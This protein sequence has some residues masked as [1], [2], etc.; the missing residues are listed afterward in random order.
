MESGEM[1]RTLPF[2]FSFL[3][4]YLSCMKWKERINRCALE[5]RKVGGWGGGRAGEGK[6]I[7]YVWYVRSLCIYTY[8]YGVINNR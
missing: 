8:L 2:F 7:V 6:L 4:L 5:K 3:F 1:D